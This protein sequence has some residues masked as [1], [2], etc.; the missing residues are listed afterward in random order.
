M[1]KLFL[2]TTIC[3]SVVSFA[4]TEAQSRKQR[5][6]GSVEIGT[7]QVVEKGEIGAASVFRTVHGISFGPNC[8]LGIGTGLEINTSEDLY[9]PV[10]LRAKYS[11][12]N[13]WGAVS[14]FAAAETG[15]RIML[16]S[17]SMAEDVSY[18]AGVM[19]GVD[20]SRYSVAFGYTLSSGSATAGAGYGPAVLYHKQSEVFCVFALRF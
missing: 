1:K 19:A 3:F 13:K 7:R 20:V 16:D 12:E 18:N 5:Y 15:T 9:V 14:P 11:F 2:L 8:F 10:F 6:E 4:Q 17:S